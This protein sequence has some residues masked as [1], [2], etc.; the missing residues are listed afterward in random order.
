MKQLPHLVSKQYKAVYT[1]SGSDYILSVVSSL[2]HALI[3][4]VTHNIMLTSFISYKLA[5][6]IISILSVNITS[7]VLIRKHVQSSEKVYTTYHSMYCNMRR[8]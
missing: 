6:I 8:V 5:K 1:I 2:G 3:C 7:T 4:L